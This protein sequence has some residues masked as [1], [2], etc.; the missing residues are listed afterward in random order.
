VR[1]KNDYGSFAA[2]TVFRGGKRRQDLGWMMPIIIYDSDPT[3]FALE[4][5]TA[6]RILKSQKRFG[7][8]FEGYLQLKGNGGRRQ[9]VVNIMFA[10]YGQA[11][12]TE[13]LAAL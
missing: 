8:L 2:G 13:N 10:R 11:Y 3:G 12:L 9:S 6:V 7:Y 5:K 4:L 1:L